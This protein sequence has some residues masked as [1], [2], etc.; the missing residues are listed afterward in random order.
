MLMNDKVSPPGERYLLALFNANPVPTFIVDGDM[1]IQDS[2]SA[3]SSLIRGGLEP[4]RG[5]RSGEAFH[6]IHSAARGC[7]QA[8]ACRRC[9]VRNSVKNVLQGGNSHRELHKAEI[10]NPAGGVSTIDQLVTAVVLP[11]EAQPRALLLL[12]DV[13]EIMALRALLPVCAYC[14]KVRDDENYWRSLEN[15]LHSHL[16]MKM[17]H[18]M[19]PDCFERET[20]ALQ[21]TAAAATAEPESSG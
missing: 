18:G 16:G 12:E 6:C 20:R 21:A 3:G 15:Y 10:R 4:S 17:T 1:R 11:D 8:E 13:S 5:R 19:C 2:N 7:G 14:R 9:V